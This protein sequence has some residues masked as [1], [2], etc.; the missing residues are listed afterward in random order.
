MRVMAVVEYDGTNYAGWQRQNNA[1]TVQQVLEE[2]I[3]RATGCRV[4]VTGAGR[5]DSGVHAVGQCAHFDLETTIP[6]DKLAYAL[7]LVLP[8][9]I[10]IRETRKV[11][12]DF[13]ARKDAIGKHYRYTIFNA[14][15][16]CAINRHYC[17]HV[18][19]AL[20]VEAMRVAAGYIKGT[21]DFACFRAAGSTEMKSTVRTITEIDV[22]RIGDF[23]YLDVKGTGFL[24]NMVRIIA[25]TLLEVGRGRRKAESIVDVIAS[26]DR[27]FAG[28][29]A[30]AKGLTM[31]SVT[32][33]YNCFLGKNRKK[34]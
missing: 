22:K 9:D 20:D 32:Y 12:E 28:P 14:P 34:D 15:H 13:H 11:R 17:T 29:T 18:R 3:E 21:H 2:A 5:T 26:C 10:R 23:V 6:A 16:D 27:N 30:P 25:G 7:N 8:E 1:I 31:V 4:S 33:P 24:Y 19:Y